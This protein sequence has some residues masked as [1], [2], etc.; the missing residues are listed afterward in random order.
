MPTE[1][2]MPETIWASL[3]ATNMGPLWV[4]VFEVIR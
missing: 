2:E 1:N 3:V 4:I